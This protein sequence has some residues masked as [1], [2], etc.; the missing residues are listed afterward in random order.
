MT[1]ISS[2]HL[3]CAGVF[4]VCRCVH[5]VDRVNCV[6]LTDV[7]MCRVLDMLLSYRA[8][9]SGDVHVQMSLYIDGDRCTVL[10]AQHSLCVLCVC[11]SV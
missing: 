7:C 3:L 1:D 4:F 8:E 10:L 11:W 5:T 6:G 2:K 9:Q